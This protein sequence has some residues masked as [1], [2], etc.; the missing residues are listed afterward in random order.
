MEAR[1]AGSIAGVD[2][3]DA[4]GGQRRESLLA[5][6]IDDHDGP[7]AGRRVPFARRQYDSYVSTSNVAAVHRKRDTGYVAG[8]A[9][10]QKKRR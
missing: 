2:L 8:L 9:A 1:Y 6:R 4:G 5:G 10:S 7:C 3:V